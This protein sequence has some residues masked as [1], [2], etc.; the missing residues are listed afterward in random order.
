MT[1]ILELGR[2]DDIGEFVLSLEGYFYSK[3]Q[4]IVKRSLKRIHMEGPTH[5]SGQ[6]G[7][8]LGHV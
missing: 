2:L 1:T 8:S 3:V 7:E 4:G 6:R 5:V